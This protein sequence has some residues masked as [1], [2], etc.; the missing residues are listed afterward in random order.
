[1]TYHI[2]VNQ[3]KIGGDATAAVA[4]YVKRLSAFAVVKVEKWSKGFAP[5]QV[6]G[7]GYSLYLVKESKH[8]STL[9]SEGFAAKVNGL[10]V[11]GVSKVNV[12]VGYDA[13][14][15]LENGEHFA[16][17]SMTLPL[18]VQLIAFTEQLYRAYTI[19]NGITYHK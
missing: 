16:V 5:S 2:Y 4:E 14:E 11:S 1:M 8:A 3:K 9:T 10:A 18:D 13:P 12:F 7:G 15:V 17:T 19:N 6:A